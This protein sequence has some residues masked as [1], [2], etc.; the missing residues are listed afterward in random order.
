MQ[1]YPYK[2][3]PLP[4]DYDAL[5]PY[6]DSETMR[7]HH[8]EHYQ[9]Y[10]DNLNKALEN[11][12][13]LHYLTLNDLLANLSQVPPFIRTQVRNN[14]GGVFNHELFFKTLGKNTNPNG[15]LAKM[16]ISQYGSIDRFKELI[17]KAAL[18]RF[19]SGW[20]W[21][22]NDEQ[23]KLYIVSTPN[24]D[25]TLPMSINPIIPLD[26]WEHAYYL[27]YKNKKSDY[28]DNWFNII[29]WDQAEN[30]YQNNIIDKE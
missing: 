28:I 25:T 5:E 20:A 14:G 3:L 19:G 21:L 10:V 12:P 23:G 2:V 15:E 29:N 26:V 8:N 27:K 18:E 11:Q 9:T 16:I 7:L 1:K 17:K 30:N 13:Q 24:Q 22:G 4:Y 6:I